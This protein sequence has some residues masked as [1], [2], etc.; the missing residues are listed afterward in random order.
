MIRRA[1]ESILQIYFSGSIFAFFGVIDIAER[2]EVYYPCGQI[3]RFI[4]RSRNSW[5]HGKMKYLSFGVLPIQMTFQEDGDVHI[6][7][8]DQ[9]ETLLN[10]IDWNEGLLQGQFYGEVKTEDTAHVPHIILLD[11]RLGGKKM[12]GLVL[13]MDDYWFGLASWIQLSR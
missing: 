1:R 6:K 5:R 13:A 2:P 4:G 9:M 7:I 11:M 12:S 8:K 3:G 10:N